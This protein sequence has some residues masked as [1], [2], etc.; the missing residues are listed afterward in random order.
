MLSIFFVSMLLV[1]FIICFAYFLNWYYAS[2]SKQ[3]AT[4]MTTTPDG[5]R[6]AIHHYEGIGQDGVLPV[7]LCHG[8]SSNRFIFDMEG[9]SSLACYLRN[10]GYDVWVPELRGSGM[11]D[12]PGLLSS[13]SC[14]TWGYEDHL[15]IDVPHIIDFVTGKTGASEV[16]WIGHSMGGMLIDSHLATVSD[17]KIAS[18]IT[19]GSPVDFSKIDDHI[20]KSFLKFKSI[21]KYIPVNPLPFLGRLLVPFIGKTPNFVHGLY[22][23]PN[24]DPH[25]ARRISCIGSQLVSS[26]RLWTDMGYFLETGRFGSS[27]GQFF[28]DGLQSCNAPIL[29][30]AGTRDYMAPE[31]SVVEAARVRDALCHRELLVAG[32]ISGFEEDY[33][34]ID[35]LVGLRAQYEIY[36]VIETWL[37]RFMA[38]SDSGIES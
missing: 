22:Y 19:L 1:A 26:G 34:H 31:A 27:D 35:M 2:P 38:K 37:Q 28:L 8:L 15:K 16:Q 5:W 11:S 32:K 33:G 20:F 6:L 17:H 21:L 30:I 29:V 18:A 7:I 12:A 13:R 25:V 36:P 23:L 14:H 3:D 9:A 10:A 24:I 4:Y